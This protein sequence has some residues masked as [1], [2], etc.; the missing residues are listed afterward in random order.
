MQ[1]QTI[2]VYLPA[3][4]LTIVARATRS[5]AVGS[6][7]LVI[8]YTLTFET[9]SPVELDHTM[10]WC[11][12]EREKGDS[13]TVYSQPARNGINFFFFF[14]DRPLR[15]KRWVQRLYSFDKLP[16]QFFNKFSSRTC[17]HPS[18]LLFPPPI[19]TC[20]GRPGSSPSVP[21]LVR[22]RLHT[23]RRVVA[24]SLVLVAGTQVHHIRVPASHSLHELEVRRRGEHIGLG[25]H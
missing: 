24:H 15:P 7:T 12:L 3:P 19:S 23:A 17:T 1:V 6:L 8:A 4:L 25:R 5:D 20:S 22:T 18:A 9:S 11:L 2:S 13:W 14:R 21:F 16:I 10:H